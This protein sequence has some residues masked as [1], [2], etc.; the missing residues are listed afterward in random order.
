LACA[1]IAEH[2][3]SIHFGTQVAI[4]FARSPT[5]I[6]YTAWDLARASKGRFILGLGTQVK[7]H[8]ERRFG[9]PW[10]ESVTG[11]LREQI[12]AIRALWESW[13]NDTQLNF[14]G[15]YYKLT[16]MTPFFNPGP[17]DYPAI[18][19]YIS[20]V[21]T[22]LAHLAGEIADGFHVHPLH[23]VRYLTDV[24]LPAINQGAR[25]NGSR[26]N[27]CAVSITTFIATTLE[28]EQFV[29]QQIAFY[30][31]TPSYLPVLALHGWES[32]AQELTRLA[33]RNRWEEMPAL[34]GDEMLREF[35]VI[36]NNEDLPER[37]S[38][39]YRGLADHLTLYRPFV[40][41][42]DD[43]LWRS[44]VQAFS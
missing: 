18:P 34:I 17:I 15:N 9:M 28:E 12:E 24:L 16:L 22:G 27:R 32:V 10:P 29:R 40:P 43:E 20:G 14:R 39:R 6:A 21:N 41:G 37:L 5:T 1:I 35:A 23:S 19:I 44:L 30:A 33:G 3:Q 42:E 13:Q 7:A 11:Q 31:S 4:S 38:Q 2:S 25:K 36:S 26:K 8:I